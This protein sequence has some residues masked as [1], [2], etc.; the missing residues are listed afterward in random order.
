MCHVDAM[1]IGLFSCSWSQVNT[2]LTV[3]AVLVIKA[4][5]SVWLGDE[6]A[7]NK[8]TASPIQ[9]WTVVHPPGSTVTYSYERGQCEIAC[10]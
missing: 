10:R 5:H 3:L 1:W 2:V 7:H 6:L 4:V 8:V 9:V